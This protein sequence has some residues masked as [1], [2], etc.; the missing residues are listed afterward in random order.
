MITAKIPVETLSQC[1]KDID[2]KDVDR[3]HKTKTGN[4]R[5]AHTRHHD[6]IAHPDR[7]RQNLFDNKRQNQPL[8]ILICKHFIT[9]PIIPLNVTIIAHIRECASKLR[10]LL[11]EVKKFCR[12]CGFISKVW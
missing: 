11:P 3:I 12:V 5:L 9:L 2:Q 8:Q 6:R 10:K 1:G 4:R 7:Y